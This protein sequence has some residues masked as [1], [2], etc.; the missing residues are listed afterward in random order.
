MNMWERLRLV[1]KAKD[2]L[3][4]TDV[5][6]LHCLAARHED[7]A[8]LY[9][10]PSEEEWVAICDNGD[11]AILCIEERNWDVVDW[12]RDY[13]REL[14]F[15]EVLDFFDAIGIEVDEL[16]PEGQE[17]EA[18]FAEWLDAQLNFALQFSNRCELMLQVWVDNNADSLEEE[19]HTIMQRLDE[20]E[21]EL[22]EQLTAK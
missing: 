16:E 14:P 12:A 2:L 9:F 21:S 6:S 11:Y 4:L 17:D 18:I 3:S 10:D 8:C 13:L 1:R 15:D 5:A 22:V 19:F 7:G 20:M